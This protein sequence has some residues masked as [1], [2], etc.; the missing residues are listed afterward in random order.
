SDSDIEVVVLPD[1]RIDLFFTQSA[2]EPFHV[3][4][5][6]IETQ[7]GQATVTPKR[8]T[9]AIS[10]RPLATEYVFKSTVANLFDNVKHLSNDFWNFSADDLNDFDLFC[11]KATQKIQSLIP[12]E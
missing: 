3:I 4:L 5:L 6:G 7:H 9:F 1:G 8:Q 10:F 11:E 2:T 12:E